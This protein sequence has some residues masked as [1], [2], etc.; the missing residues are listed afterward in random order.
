MYEFKSF[1]LVGKGIDTEMRGD[2]VSV[3]TPKKRPQMDA[4]ETDR[5]LAITSASEVFDRILDSVG[6]G[7]S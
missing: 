4:D 2:G 6:V 5:E 3:L 1:K 7:Y